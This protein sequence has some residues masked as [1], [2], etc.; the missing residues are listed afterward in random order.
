MVIMVTAAMRVVVAS[1]LWAILK[2]GRG[3]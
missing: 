1:S 2:R 3:G